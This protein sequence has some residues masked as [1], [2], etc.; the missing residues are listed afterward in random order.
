MKD[1]N[2]S[3]SAFDTE[4]ALVKFLDMDERDN[5][6]IPAHVLNPLL[7]VLET[8]KRPCSA[9]MFFNGEQQKPF[10][11]VTRITPIQ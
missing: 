1:I 8:L 11:M 9:S 4:S 10:Y 7:R 3:I 6:E 5:L 2:P